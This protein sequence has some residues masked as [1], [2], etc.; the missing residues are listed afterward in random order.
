[1]SSVLYLS[2]QFLHQLQGQKS[3]TIDCH[4]VSQYKKNLQ[5][6]RQRK[7]WKT[8]G[9]GAQFMGVANYSE[10][11]ELAH[12]YPVDAVLIDEQ[13][14]IYAAQLQDG[15]AI[16]IKSLLDLQ[17]PEALILRNNEF[18]IHHM[19]Y[20]AQNKRLVLSASPE[21][22]YERHLC[23]LGLDSNR[24]QYVTE[25][26]CQ[27]QHPCFDPQNPDIIY[28][29]S[30][31]FA[32]DQQ[33]S[34]SIGPR[35]V[36]RL[37]LQ[38]G[39]LETIIADPRYDC[40][41]PKIDAK[42]QLHFLKRPYKNQHYRGNSLKDIVSAPF[43]IIRAVFGWLDFFTQRYTGESLKS[44]SGSNPAKSRQKSEEEL[45]VEGNLIKAQK[46][47]QQNQNAGEKFAGV[48]PRSWELVLY[49]STGEQ[50]VLKRGV[51]SYNLNT[52]DTVLYSNGKHLISIAA[53]QTETMLVE[54]KLIQKIIC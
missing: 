53:D 12:V 32:Y 18:I 44:T 19:D 14:L 7:Q 41:K 34:V 13:H 23:I 15:C 54:A 31:G 27:D 2:D 33:G 43:K 24:I 46:A 52:E 22:A 5:E 21:H 9:T 3:H 36:C 30:C 37:N 26:D 17:Q 35:E 50:K 29:D 4:A 39:D 38:T 40:Y 25:G 8:S 1:M 51:L 20:D 6:I 47:V 28:Y 11:E 42:G 10:Q 45:F 16:Y 48:I 49:S